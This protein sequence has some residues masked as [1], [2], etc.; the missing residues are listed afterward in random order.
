M[1][2]IKTMA[3]EARIE[4]NAHPNQTSYDAGYLHGYADALE[5]IAEPWNMTQLMQSYERMCLRE[6]AAW[7]LAIY[8]G[9]DPEELDE[10]SAP[11]VWQ[12]FKDAVG[13]TYAEACSEGKETYLLDKLVDRFEKINDSNIAVNDTW[14]NV[15]WEFV[16]DRK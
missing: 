7:Q 12:D 16:N 15:I 3:Q 8:F 10:E 9:C 4:A 2:N 11:D 1:R 5:K 13:C 6:D 14:H